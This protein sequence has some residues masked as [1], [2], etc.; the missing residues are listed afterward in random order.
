MRIIAL[1]ILV[2]GLFGTADYTYAARCDCDYSKRVRECYATVDWKKDMITVTSTSNACSY[3]MWDAD[4]QTLLTVVMDGIDERVPLNIMGGKEIP[5]KIF[6]KS[7]QICKDEKYPS[8]AKQPG[9]YGISP[10]LTKESLVTLDKDY[11]YVYETLVQEQQ[12]QQAGQ[13]LGKIFNNSGE[14]VG[15]GAGE[16]FNSAGNMLSNAGET[17]MNVIT[18][19]AFINTLTITNAVLQGYNRG[20]IIQLQR[21]RMRQQQQQRPAGLAYERPP[22]PYQPQ[23]C[24]YSRETNNSNC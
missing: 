4:G 9:P 21:N 2:F 1:F 12:P 17:F 15:Q 6:V 16:M 3:V 19:D 20:R 11:D 13:Q 7:C 23:P 22:Q 18:S 14:Q 8:A 5:K 24:W 10:A